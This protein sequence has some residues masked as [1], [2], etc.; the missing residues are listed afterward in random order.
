MSADS[1]TCLVIDNDLNFATFIKR[2]TEG[3][4]LTTRVLT[5]PMRLE[6]ALSDCAPDVITLHMEMPSRPGLE[7]LMELSS[8][9]LE[10]RVIIISGAPP[11]HSGERPQVDGCRVIAVLTKP[12]RKLEIEA[13]LSRALRPPHGAD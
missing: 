13:A 5:N 3:I 4:G 1:K 10:E 7:V 11:V 8:R 6:E 2:V 9:R 12:A